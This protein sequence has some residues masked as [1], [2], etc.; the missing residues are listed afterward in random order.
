[1]KKF[2]LDGINYHY[3][4]DATIKE[5]EKELIIDG[6]KR[7]YLYLEVYIGSEKI[8]ESVDYKIW[9]NGYRT[10]YGFESYIS[11]RNNIEEI[12]GL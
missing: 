10:P 1:M 9:D 8:H 5:L 6:E 7:E 3:S 11:M 12:I 2:T 4:K